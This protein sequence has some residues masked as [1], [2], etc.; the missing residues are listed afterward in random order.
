M[1]KFNATFNV[2]PAPTGDIEMFLD[3]GCT[4]SAENQSLSFGSILW[5]DIPTGTQVKCPVSIPVWFK[6]T[7]NVQRYFR[8]KTQVQSG[9]GGSLNVVIGGIPGGALSLAAGAV[10]ASILSAALQESYEGEVVVSL[11]VHGEYIP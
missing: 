4:E 6:N 7:G 10:K 2:A 11:E 9:P 3:A 8:S 5:K 1:T